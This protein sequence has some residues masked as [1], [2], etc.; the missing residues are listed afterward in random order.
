MFAVHLQHMVFYFV[1]LH[2]T[3]RRLDLLVDTS[4][5]GGP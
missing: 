5:M 1:T 3:N 2:V 4:G